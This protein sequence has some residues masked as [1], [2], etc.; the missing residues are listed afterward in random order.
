MGQYLQKTIDYI[1]RFPTAAKIQAGGLSVLAVLSFQQN[2]PDQ[3]RLLDKILASDG[4][5]YELRLHEDDFNYGG[6]FCFLLEEETEKSHRKNH[7]SIDLVA[8][9]GGTLKDGTGTIEFC[10]GDTVV[11]KDGEIVEIRQRD[12]VVSKTGEITDIGHNHTY[13]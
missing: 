1:A 3:G 8:L 5:K 4:T 13:D 10:G 2:N 7:I 6:Q 12:R 9:D 11:L